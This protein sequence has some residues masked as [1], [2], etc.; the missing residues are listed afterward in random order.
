MGFS[1][2][3]L[4][5]CGERPDTLS[6]TMCECAPPCITAPPSSQPSHTDVRLPLVGSVRQR[7]KNVEGKR[8]E[9]GRGAMGADCSSE[10]SPQPRSVRPSP[11]VSSIGDDRGRRTGARG[12]KPNLRVDD[13]FGFDFEFDYDLESLSSL[14]KCRNGY[15]RG[16]NTKNGVRASHA[17]PEPTLSSSSDESG[18]SGNH[19]F[20][21][22]VPRKKLNLWFDTLPKSPSAIKPIAE[23]DIYSDGE[24]EQRQWLQ[25]EAS[26]YYCYEGD[27]GDSKGVR[28][29]P[30]YVSAL[31]LQS[32]GEREEVEE[33]LR[34]QRQ[35]QAKQQQQQRQGKS[36]KKT[37]VS[38]CA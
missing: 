4:Y 36:A 23:D 22:F 34:L 25:T 20:I 30:L 21:G 3:K 37:Q 13:D 31:G 9:S 35:R 17:D 33:R 24:R 16:E 8:R 38:R 1:K 6:F 2:G 7:T 28:C 27:R 12:K 14:E 29:Q 32:Q 11:V 19:S 10:R 5:I 26:N 18:C 15:R